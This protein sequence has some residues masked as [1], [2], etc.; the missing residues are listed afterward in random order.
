[1]QYRPSQ[2]VQAWPRSNLSQNF[3]PGSR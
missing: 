1:L 3:C 2:S